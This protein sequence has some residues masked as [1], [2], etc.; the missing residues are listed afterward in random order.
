MPDDSKMYRCELMAQSVLCIKN[1]I[2]NAKK[3]TFIRL[4][5]CS[6]LMVYIPYEWYVKPQWRP[7]ILQIRTLEK[8]C[9]INS[10]ED[11]DR[12]PSSQEALQELGKHRD[13]WSI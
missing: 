6:Y 8:K 10:G 1:L 4:I 12:Q 3:S 2:I 7:T 13:G 11:L 9:E 5:H